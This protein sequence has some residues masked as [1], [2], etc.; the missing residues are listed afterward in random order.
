MFV[1]NY[2]SNIGAL[3]VKEGDYLKID[4]YKLDIKL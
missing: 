3:F 2:I 1:L 4:R